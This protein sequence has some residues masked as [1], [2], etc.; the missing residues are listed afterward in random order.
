MKQREE[1]NSRREKRRHGRTR[2][3]RKGKDYTWE[4]MGGEGRRR[5]ER[6]EE[7]EGERRRGEM[8]TIPTD[9]GRGSDGQRHLKQPTRLAAARDPL[10]A[11]SN[12][13][14]LGSC[15]ITHMSPTASHITSSLSI[16]F[17]LLYKAH[18]VESINSIQL[19][20][21]D[22]SFQVNSWVGLIPTL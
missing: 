21:V 22:R 20:Q 12:N 4:E 18:R 14:Q 15:L 11:N 1:Q 16:C 10:V 6:R 3:N 5:K 19:I 17:L 2:Q 9:C 8:K 7:R 13:D